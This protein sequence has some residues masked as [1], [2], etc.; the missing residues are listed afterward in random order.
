MSNLQVGQYI[1]FNEAGVFLQSF[2]RCG[3]LVSDNGDTL[4]VRV[5][6][7]EVVI[8]KSQVIGKGLGVVR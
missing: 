7:N 5:R 2:S 3:R 6:G 1:T 4:T 8:D